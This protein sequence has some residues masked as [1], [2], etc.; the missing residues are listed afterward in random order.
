MAAEAYFY[1]P[2]S[3]VY[4]ITGFI[5]FTNYGKFVRVAEIGDYSRELC[6]GIHVSRT[7]EIGLLKV[8]GSTN[9]RRY[10]I[11]L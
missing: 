2:G 5:S 10:L 4:G 9:D 1:G 7:G 8:E 3:G 11:N 6:G